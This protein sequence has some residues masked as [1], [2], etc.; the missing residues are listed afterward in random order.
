MGKMLDK[1]S[2]SVPE[3]TALVDAGR[4]VTYGRLQERAENL[5]AG[6]SALG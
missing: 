2:E 3:K 4:R 6:L 5:A 1:S